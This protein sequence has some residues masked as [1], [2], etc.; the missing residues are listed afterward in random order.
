MAAALAVVLWA[1]YRAA[2]LPAALFVLFVGFF[3]VY[4]GGHYPSDV[5]AGFI[6]GIM[7]GKAFDWMKKSVPQSQSLKVKRQKENSK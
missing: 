2:R 1:D 5:I 6:I 7:I 3:C 4:T